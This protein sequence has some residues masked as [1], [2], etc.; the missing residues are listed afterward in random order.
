MRSLI[1]CLPTSPATLATPQSA[2]V[3]AGCD[4]LGDS[5]ASRTLENEEMRSL[6]YPSCEEIVRSLL[7]SRDAIG[8]VRR[9]DRRNNNG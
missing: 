1:H 9:G 4:S 6:I 2:A 3:A 7:L 5:Y 8:D